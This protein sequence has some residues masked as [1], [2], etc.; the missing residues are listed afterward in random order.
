M[1]F[2]KLTRESMVKEFKNHPKGEAFYSRLAKVIMGEPSEDAQRVKR[3][4]QEERARKKADMST[5]VFVND[6]PVYKLVNFS[7]GKF[8]EQMLNDIL[9]QVQ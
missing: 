8:T 9:A 3:T 1:T 6:M 5:L 2:P 4:P 7:E